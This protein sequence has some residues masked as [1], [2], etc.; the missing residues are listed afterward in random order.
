MSLYAHGMCVRERS[1]GNTEDI[2]ELYWER[3][4]EMVVVWLSVRG[5][6]AT[7]W[8]SERISL[9]LTYSLR[10]MPRDHLTQHPGYESP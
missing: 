7:A 8:Y 6:M 3:R 5:M 4:W 10:A 9:P 1:C 2:M